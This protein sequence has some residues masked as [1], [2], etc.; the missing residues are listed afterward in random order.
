MTNVPP[1]RQKSR[2]LPQTTTAEDT[3]ALEEQLE[4][5]LEGRHRGSEEKEA[6]ED[7]ADLLPI[8]N[9]VFGQVGLEIG[10]SM[11]FCEVLIV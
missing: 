7:P 5:M 6:E 9:S 10:I 3:K 1:Q 4:E 8:V 2:Q 11:C